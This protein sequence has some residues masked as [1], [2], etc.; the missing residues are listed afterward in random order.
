MSNNGVKILHENH[1]FQVVQRPEMDNP[2][3]II[4]EGNV[5]PPEKSDTVY[6][7]LL[8]TALL[9]CEITTDELIKVGDALAEYFNS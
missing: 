4:V 3:L 6:S 7:T 8:N 5:I 1:P 2:S 9:A